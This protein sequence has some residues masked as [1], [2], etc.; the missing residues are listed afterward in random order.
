MISIDSES[1]ANTFV[2]CFFA[3]GVFNTFRMIFSRFCPKPAPTVGN[4][5]DSLLASIKQSPTTFSSASLK[6]DDTPVPKVLTFAEQ[7]SALEEA[8]GTRIIFLVTRE[9]SPGIIP[10]PVSS[11]I[12]M[13]DARTFVNTLRTIPRDQ[14]IDLIIDT[15]GGEFAATEVIVNAMLNRG[16]YVNVFVPFRA[17]SA[18]TLISFAGDR[19]YLGQNAFLGP[20]DTTWNGWSLPSIARNLPTDGTF[21][22]VWSY[23][24]E[25]CNR[26]AARTSNLIGRIGD[27]IEDFSP[28]SDLDNTF[29][30]ATKYDH[31]QPLFYKDVS[32]VGNIRDTNEFPAEI[33][34]IFEKYQNTKTGGGGLFGGGGGGL[35]GG[36]LF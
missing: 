32:F 10:F 29:L 17:T 15:P 30:N 23:L 4:S 18:G 19:V 5:M 7:V 27:N 6:T 1:V 14:T 11:G 35:F 28:S 8:R 33:Y 21:S 22:M 25:V 2:A 16:G 3:V 13:A 36:G 9:K 34:D 12:T 20:V 31:D 26:D 24:R